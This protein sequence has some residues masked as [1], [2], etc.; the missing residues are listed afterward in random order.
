M[1]DIFINAIYIFND[2]INETKDIEH[3]KVKFN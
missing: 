1:S 2:E 3:Y